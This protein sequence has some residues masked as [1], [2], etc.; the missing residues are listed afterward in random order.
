MGASGARLRGLEASL[1]DGIQV[2]RERCGLR[3]T[4]LALGNVYG[5]DDTSGRVVPSLIKAAREA[6]DFEV[7]DA[8]A[9]RNFTHIDDV[10]EAVVKCRDF[11]GPLLNIAGPVATVGQVADM[12]AASC[13]AGV[14]RRSWAGALFA[15][16]MEGSRPRAQLALPH[17][18]G[19]RTRSAVGGA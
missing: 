5:P 9:Q 7:R 12:L 6:A 3:G 16:L 1:G 8:D 13:I 10:V 2:L 14:R 17:R 11:D 4:M 18:A 15:S 19:G